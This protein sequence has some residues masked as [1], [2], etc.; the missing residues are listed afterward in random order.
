M[1]SPLRLTPFIKPPGSWL[2]P[3]VASA[4]A[5]R[6]SSPRSGWQNQDLGTW[7]LLGPGW[8]GT[9]RERKIL[10]VQIEKFTLLRQISAG[11]G[12]CSRWQCWCSCLKDIDTKAVLTIYQNV[13]GPKTKKKGVSK[14]G[15]ASARTFRRT[16]TTA[17][18]CNVSI[19]AIYVHKPTPKDSDNLIMR[20]NLFMWTKESNLFQMISWRIGVIF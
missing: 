2:H 1:K 14:G 11:V 8:L 3:F 19:T 10:L 20:T 18:K 12:S 7:G 5:F 16:E 15:E 4:T 6:F 17:I 9:R 13:I